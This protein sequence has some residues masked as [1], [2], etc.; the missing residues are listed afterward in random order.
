[1]KLT[2]LLSFGMT[3]LCGCLAYGNASDPPKLEIISAIYGQG[4]EAV[5]ITEKVRKEVKCGTYLSIQNHPRFTGKEFKDRKADRNLRIVYKLG[6]EK[7]ESVSKYNWRVQLGALPA[8]FDFGTPEWIERFIDFSGTAMALSSKYDPSR[9]KDYFCPKCG[10]ENCVAFLPYEEDPM[11]CAECGFVFSD[12]TLPVT[13]ADVFEGMKHEYHQLPDGTKI[14]WKPVLRCMKVL[15]AYSVASRT[16]ARDIPTARKKLNTMLAYGKFYRKH[17]VRGTGK[18]MFRPGYPHECNYGRL[19][20]FGDYVFPTSFCGMYRDIE[21]SG[22]RITPEERAEYRALLEDIISE[23]TLPF[24]RQWRGMGNPMGAAF[25]DCINV[26]RTFPEA[27]II[28]YYT[29]DEKGNPRILS[30]TDLVYETVQG[31]NG[32]ENLVSTYWYSDGLMHEPT[33]AYQVMLAGGVSKLLRNHLDGFQPPAGYDPV[34]RGYQPFPSSS[35]A[36]RP[37]LLRPLSRHHDVAFPNGEAIPFGDAL[38]RMITKNPPKES[39]LYHGWGVGA[40]RHENTVAAMNWG[41]LQDGHS[42]ND[43]LNLL[44]WGDG[45]LMLNTTEYPANQPKVPIQY[46]RAGAGAHNTVMIDGKNHERARGGA[47]AWGVTDHLKVMQGFADKSHPGAVL[48]R[49]AFLVNSRPGL[50]PYLV[51]F[52]QADGGKESC[53]YFLQAQSR[54]GEPLE[55][56]EVISPKMSPTGK[57]DLS[58]VFSNAEKKNVY[59]F[60][61]NPEEGKF[62]GNAELLWTLPYQ[63]AALHLRGILVPGLRDADTLYV[64]N[65]PGCR[66][67]GREIDPLDRVARKVVWRKKKA[68]PEK[69]MH[70]CFLAAFEYAKEK[71]KLDLKAVNR[72]NVSGP[73][74]SRAAE[75]THGNGKDILLLS[76]GNGTMSV[77]TSAGKIAFD[78][79]AAL[80]SLERNGKLLKVTTTGGRFLEVNGKKIPV[81]NLSRGKLAGLPSGLSEWLQ[82]EKNATVIVSGKVPQ[83]AIGNML[84]VKHRIA[85]ASYKIIGVKAL[86]GNR[87]ELQ[88]DRS[89]RKLIAVVDAAPNRKDMTVLSGGGDNAAPGDN[90]VIDGKAY[91]ILSQDKS[92]IRHRA[93]KTLG[94]ATLKLANPLPES[95]VQRIPVTEFGP[96]DPYTV[97]T[98]RTVELTE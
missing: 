5:D 74:A 80:L 88:L 67:T 94:Y 45:A 6:D 81:G 85:T 41:N 63:G 40:L 21:K 36:D 12:K 25:G 60:I 50:P 23:I 48:R 44:Y 51:D 83:E 57:R 75:V 64:G 87:T 9:R 62:S 98:S 17:M 55:K 10:K 72:L 73:S 47:G 58:Q 86:S 2:G 4:P 38:S 8:R 37:D 49:T 93:G 66:H 1:M 59:P 7:K 71:D 24:I 91:K 30:G 79:I 33:V 92:G 26:G 28:D 32:L 70:S 3:V 95:G 61:K 52:Y 15:Y 29:L 68:P 16:R 46:W 27:R 69:E 56:L 82:N 54:Y 65:A 22:L 53:D 34:K 39:D 90:F 89:A 19:C 42:H 84:I 97:M 78:G 76:D 20:H 13:G 14:Y 77:N 18:K 35:F 31:R 43:M 11:Q 96:D